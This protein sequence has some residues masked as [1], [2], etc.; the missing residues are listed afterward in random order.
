MP[1][2]DR[3]IRQLHLFQAPHKYVAQAQRQRRL[4]GTEVENESGDGIRIK[5]VN[6]IGIGSE[7]AI[8][9]NNRYERRRSSVYVHADGAAGNHP[10]G[11]ADNVNR[12]GYT[13]K[14]GG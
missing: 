7:I 9:I 11:R 13:L 12:V 14:N 4:N 5:S 6:W 8:E 2:R 3:K 10:Q 1:W